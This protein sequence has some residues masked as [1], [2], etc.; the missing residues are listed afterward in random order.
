MREGH[1]R[2]P[3]E[4][5]FSIL[6]LV[7][8]IVLLFKAYDI[9][10]LSSLSSAGAVPIGAAATMVISAAVIAWKT[11]KSELD[12][13]ET[14][15]SAILPR[16]VWIGI[17]LIIAYAFL[18]VPLGFLPTSFLFLAIM[19]KLL[20]GRSV[21]FATWTSALSVLIIYLVFRIVFVVLMPE[22][23]VPEG[24]IISAIAAMFGGK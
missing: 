13:T 4:A 2:R 1:I 23:I 17:A 16:D 10:G 15:A 6:L 3:G 21:W 8:S 18:L 14:F 5:V 7:F 24:R 19:I 9:D 20:S 11:N 22:G 12:K